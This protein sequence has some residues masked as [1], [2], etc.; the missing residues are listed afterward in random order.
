MTFR[1]FMVAL[2]AAAL[3]AALLA[4]GWRKAV[5]IPESLEV[6]EPSEA[7]GDEEIPKDPDRQRNWRIADEQGAM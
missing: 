4:Q 1:D 3:A 7:D 2:C 5:A 6:A